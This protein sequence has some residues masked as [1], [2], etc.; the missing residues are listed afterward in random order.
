LGAANAVAA[1]AS[2]T[3]ATC[4]SATPLSIDGFSVRVS[5]TTA[6]YLEGDPRYIIKITSIATAGGA[7]GNI[8]YVERSVSAGLER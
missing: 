8:G 5:C 6:T 4:T 7:P 2:I 3:A 1:P